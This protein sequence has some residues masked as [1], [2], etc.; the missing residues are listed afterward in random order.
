MLRIVTLVLTAFLVVTSPH[1]AKG[2]LPKKVP[3][4]GVLVYGSPPPAPSPEQNVIQG[5]RELG[6]VDGQNLGLVIRY[7]EGRPERLPDLAR[8]LVE[9][10]VDVVVAVGTDVSKVVRSVTATIPIVMSASE[11]PVELGLVATLSR[12]GGNMTGVTFISSELA[13]KRL[14][15]L[16]EVVPRASRM[17]VLWNPT[18]VDL[19]FKQLEVAGRGLG[20]TLQSVEVRSP[21][22]LDGAFRAIAGGRADALMVV[23]SRLINLNLKRIAAFA[24]ERR[25]PAV[26]MWRSFAEVGGLITYGPD[27]GAMI[28]RTASHVDRVLKG[29]KPGDLPVERPTHFELVVNLTTAKALGLTV[30]QS[31]L[32]RA[33]RVIE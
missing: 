19:E 33:D 21:E 29:A 8:E 28:K 26:S 14:E 2:Q 13:A 5:L 1:P 17:A 16:K 23:P 24:L 20:I 11:D 4:V 6:W 15:V 7:A 3:R 10:R 12:P 9:S 25:L 22:E 27:A 32:L 31:L 18:H 30:P